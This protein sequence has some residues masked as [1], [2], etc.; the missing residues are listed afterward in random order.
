MIVLSQKCSGRSN[1]LFLSLLDP[2]LP[3]KTLN[4]LGE[5]CSVSIKRTSLSKKPLE[6]E[7]RGSKRYSL[8]SDTVLSKPHIPAPT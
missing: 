7:E 8:G 2:A 1:V 4:I 5:K 3:F 6:R